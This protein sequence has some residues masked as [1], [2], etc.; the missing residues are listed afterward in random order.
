MTKRQKVLLLVIISLAFLYRLSALD[1]PLI[2]TE[3]QRDYLIAQHILT[4]QDF[5]QS[6]PC[7]IFNGSYAPYRHPVIYYYLL[8]GLLVINQN[9]MFLMF[10]NFFLQIIPL[11]TIFVLTF[12]FFSYKIGLLAVFFYSFHQETYKNAL[13]FGNRI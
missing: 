13:F 1:Y 8:A 6:G 9:F 7:C 5:P 11:I 10:V 4:Y 2:N 12:R 3:P